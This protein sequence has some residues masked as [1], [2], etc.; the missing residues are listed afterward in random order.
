M[1]RKLVLFIA[2][3][4]DGFIAGPNDDLSWLS[5]VEREGEDY[6]YGEFMATVDATIVGRRTY[7][8]VLSMGYDFPHA[9]KE[10]Y[11]ITRIEREPI[12]NIRFYSGDIKTLV[13][14]LKAKPGKTIFCDGGAEIVNLL[15]Q[16]RLIDQFIISII[17]VFL[18]SGVRLF[19][20]GI[21]GD[22]L[23][24]ISS[25]SFESGLIQVH[26]APK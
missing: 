7:D 19:K 16:D 12:G 25:K 11:I 8:K 5:E 14:S 21:P 26:Y 20:D 24:L 1:E 18:G 9:D 6:G 15:M 13:A 4:L 3:S 2:M 17:P 23:R 22:K 10:S